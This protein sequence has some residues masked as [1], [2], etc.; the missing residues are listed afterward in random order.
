VL[1]GDP[2]RGIIYGDESGWKSLSIGSVTG[3]A[4]KQGFILAVV[5]Q[6]GSFATCPKAQ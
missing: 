2:H 1:I 3:L 4:E 5:S 6:L